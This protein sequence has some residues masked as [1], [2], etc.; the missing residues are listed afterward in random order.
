MRGRGWAFL[1]A[2]HPE[3][4]AAV[5]A[6]TGLLAYGGGHPPASLL[7]VCGAVLASQLAVGWLNDAVDAR[8]DARAGRRDKP[9]AA[10]HLP[11]RAAALAAAGAALACVALSLSTGPRPGL[12]MVAAL[13]SALAY[14]WPLK[15]TPASV[16]PYAFSFGALPV[17]VLLAAPDGDPPPL[18]LPAAGAMLG[19][20]AHFANALPDLADDALT[21]VRGLPQRLG[22]RG[23][24]AAGA[25]LLA[26]ATAALT[27]G[28]PGPPAWWGWAALGAAA[29]ALAAGGLADRRAARR[30]SRQV[31]AFRAVLGLAVLDVALLVG[32]AHA[33]G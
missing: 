9:V 4:A 23:A 8:R 13:L 12:V 1:R 6:L 27:L 15:G 10:G 17:F 18:W 20:G 22:P 25:L 3:P 31:Y 32:G 26:G 28:P 21:G 30:G 2:S 5:T 29:A 19:A 14:D 33:L 24:R 11:V 7:R 16:L